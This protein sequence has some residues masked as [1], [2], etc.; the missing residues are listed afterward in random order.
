MGD[1]FSKGVQSLLQMN[2][3]YDGA[4]SWVTNS[5]PVVLMMWLL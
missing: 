5:H 3:E 1:S 4:D 2:S